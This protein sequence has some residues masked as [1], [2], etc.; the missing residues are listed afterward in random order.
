M[1]RTG[2]ISVFISLLAVIS[3]LGFLLVSRSI[4]TLGFPLDDAWIHQTYA[5]NLALTG[6]WFYVAGE[7][8]AGSTSPLWSGML[9]IGY[10]LRL[11]PYLWTYS[12]GIVLLVVMALLATKVL[13][14]IETGSD[15]FILLGGVLIGLNWHL[16]WAAV[17][18]ME[19]L[20]FACVILMV[21]FVLL[22]K[23]IPW[24]LASGLVGLSVWLRPD[25]ITLLGPLIFI[26]FFETHSRR[27]SSLDFMMATVPIV[28]L[29]LAYSVFN[30]S[31]S[32]NIFPNTF[33]AKQ[34]EYASMQ[35]VPLGLRFWRQWL[36][37]I[38]GAGVLLL[39]G[40]IWQVYIALRKRHW[41][42][43][44]WNLWLLGYVG[45]YAVMLPVA[46][47]HGRYIMPVMAVYMV[48]GCKGMADI[49][50]K[51]RRLFRANI[52]EK[53]WLS[54]VLVTLVVFWVFGARA[55]GYDVAIIE[56]EMV[57]TARWIEANTPIDAKIAVHDI[58]AIGFFTHRELIDLAGLVT[59]E[60]IPFL[61]DEEALA[62]YLDEKGVC[63]LV[64]FP[65]WYPQLSKRGR[66]VYSTQSPYSIMMGG[67]NMMVYEWN[68][69]NN[70]RLR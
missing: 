67:E 26:W 2:W 22:K 68:E 40:Y 69:T 59:P 14:A 20:A 24:W 36:P 45:M 3:A 39:P 70:C 16:T 7:P 30:F 31:L 11:N 8:S 1:N 38:T 55:Y 35:A 61:R 42:P 44:A 21:V 47:Q 58:G 4:Y 9:A 19:T 56:T 54:A 63:Y 49:F 18:G 52:L 65:G 41:N 43:I 62:H 28:S 25:G 66:Q 17:S 32:G 12:L 50:Q 23:P 27:T 53:T 60:V 15:W 46:Y 10:L 34:V 5:R 64:T 29:L 48:F 51:T 6:D 37:V 13:G 57:K 33:Y